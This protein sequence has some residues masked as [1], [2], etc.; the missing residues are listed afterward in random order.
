MLF[1]GKGIWKKRNMENNI[2][3]Y[4][5]KASSPH[6]LEKKEISKYL[7]RLKQKVLNFK[8]SRYQ[9]YIYI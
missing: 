4:W 1:I 7:I 8:K 6:P 9:M 5:K 2:F 3:K